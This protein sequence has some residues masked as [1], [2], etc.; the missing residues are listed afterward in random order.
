MISVS[1]TAVVHA[2][3]TA[4]N[5]RDLHQV[6]AL[7]ADDAVLLPTFSPH[8]LRTPVD[9]RRYFEQLTARPGLAVTLHEKT[10]RVQALG[11]DLEVASGIYRFQVEIDDEPLVFEARFTFVVAPGP[12]PIRHHHSSQIPRTLT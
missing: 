1:A 6:L 2:W 8:A 10:L 11:P 7:Y 3:M 9:R 12:A 4:L 5:A